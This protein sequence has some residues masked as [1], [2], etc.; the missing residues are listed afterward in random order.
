MACSWRVSCSLDAPAGL[1]ASSIRPRP[2]S[3][4]TGAHPP[5]DAERRRILRADGQVK[6]RGG[7]AVTQDD[8][9]YRFRLRV[10]AMA[11]E[12]GNVRAACRAMGI[13]PSTYYRWKRQLDRHGPEILRPRERRTPADGEPDQ[14]RWSSNG[15]SP[16]PWAIPASGRP[17]SPPSSPDPSGAGSMLSTNGV[18]RVLRRHGLSTR[19]KRYGLVAGYAAPPE[20]QRPAATARA[21]PCTSTIPVQLVQLD[22]FCIGRLSR[23]PRARCGSTPPSTSPRAYTWAT[24]QVTRRNPSA[25]WTSAAG[26][27]RSPPTWPPAAGGWSG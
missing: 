8:L 7:V 3:S 4:D 5:P 14:S 15:W 26:P 9:L 2:W 23:A 22:C 17:G 25:T 24:L 21:A 16:S 10:F 1:E 27:D 20:P 19:A 12:L 13:H 6:Q 18:W 11:A